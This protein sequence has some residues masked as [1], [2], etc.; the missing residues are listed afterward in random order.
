MNTNPK[1]L[2]EG[3][4]F[5]DVLLVPRR[6]SIRSRFSGEIDTSAQVA[7]G[8]PP[9]HIPL[10]SANMDTVTGWRMATTLA[11]W[12]A[13]GVIH[14]FMSID[15]QVKEARR[16]K[17]RMRVMEDHPPVI[18]ENATIADA[19]RLLHERE[20]GYVIIYEGESFDGAFVGIATPR[21]F[22]AGEP[23]TPLR[24]VMTPRER[25]WTVPPG[26]TLE[27]AVA[28]MRQRRIEKV[29]VVAEDGRLVGVYTTKDH[30]HYQ[31]YPH[32][33]LDAKGQL[34]VGAAIGVQEGDIERALR[35]VE[36]EVDVL[37]LDIAHGELDYTQEI[38]RRLKIEERI[39]TPIVAGNVA[40]VEGARY[41]RDAGADGVKVGVGPGYVCETRDV[42][43]VGI[44]QI[45]A[46]MNAAEAFA[47]DQDRLPIIGD[48]G[49]RKPGDVAKAIAAGANTVMIGSLLAGTEESPGEPV[50]QDGMLKKMVRGMASASAFEKRRALGESTTSAD[51][52]VPEGRT[53]FTPYKGKAIKVLKKLRG[54]LLSGMSYCNARSIEAMHDQAQFVIVKSPLAPE[55]RRPLQS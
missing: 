24:E 55:Q 51:D 35:L 50:E 25:M 38:L 30:E 13:F 21:D 5:D 15:E 2:G 29:P 49:I 23:V 12:G 27:G 41:V 17:E 10:L 46:I 16:V 37:V 36:A 4:G 6:S 47:S 26:T 11:L 18:P 43:G 9:I 8:V 32:A 1:I 39:R 7:R 44:P 19:Q 22:D 48:G 53:T 28:V 14:R 3:L 33:S 34:M 31:H 20:R 52:Y 42:A 54:G 45:T 40:T